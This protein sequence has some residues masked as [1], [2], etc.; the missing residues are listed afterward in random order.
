M[1]AAMSV[2]NEG[3][4]DNFLITLRSSSFRTFS[5]ITFVFRMEEFYYFK[6]NLVVM[7]DGNMR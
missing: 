7:R 2:P 6:S 3:Q 1:D 5:W 4:P